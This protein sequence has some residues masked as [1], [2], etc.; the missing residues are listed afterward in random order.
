[1]KIDNSIQK[2]IALTTIVFLFLIISC[3]ENSIPPSATNPVSTISG[4]NS[5]N[6]R[7][8]GYTFDGLEGDAINLDTANTWI[9]YYVESGQKITAGYFSKKSLQSIMGKSGCMGVRFYYSKTETGQP[10]LMAVGADKNG[11]DF[12]STYRKRGIYSAV[13]LFEKSPSETY[14]GSE[15]DSITL[16]T[17]TKWIDNYSKESPSGIIAHFFGYQIIEQLL[18]RKNC[19]GLRCYYALDNK[20]GVAKLLLIGVDSIGENILSSTISLGGRTTSEGDVVVA[21]YSFPCPTYCSGT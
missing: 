18:S 11:N 6:S 1:M 14:T 21:D 20:Q 19:V 2:R 8:A 7:I 5:A 17:S 13:S 3:N 16:E 9:N 10:I 4:K 12:Q 15:L